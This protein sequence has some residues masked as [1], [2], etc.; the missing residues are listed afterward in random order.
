MTSHYIYEGNIVRE[1]V[2]SI[3]N[4]KGIKNWRML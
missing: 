2:K 1:I 3:C 4:K